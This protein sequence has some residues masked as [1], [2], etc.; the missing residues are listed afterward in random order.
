V[1]SPN[2]ILF[3]VSLLFQGN[4]FQISPATIYWP[5]DG[6]CSQ[7]LAN[8]RDFKRSDNHLAHRRLPLG[9]HGVVC[10]LRTFR[11]E[12]TVVSDRGPFGAIQKCRSRFDRFIGFKETKKIKWHGQCHFWQTQVRLA[13][14]WQR[15][16]D[17]D[18]T[19]PL[20]KKLGHKQFEP[21]IFFYDLD[22]H[23]KTKDT[24]AVL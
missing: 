1:P 18:L 7:K 2:F 9:L 12:R 19:L 3:V 11:C 20:A 10:S 16:G 21:V 14:G 6:Q 13:K 22:T 5:G 15:R 17:F 8:G 4:T 23:W 24:V